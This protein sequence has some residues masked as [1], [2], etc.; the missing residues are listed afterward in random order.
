MKSNTF[1]AVPS[2]DGMIAFNIQSIVLFH[3]Q[4]GVR[5]VAEIGQFTSALFCFTPVSAALS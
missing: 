3:N 4:L 2:P 1:G 5:A